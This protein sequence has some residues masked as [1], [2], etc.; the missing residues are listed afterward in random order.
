MFERLV[1][2][3][4][5]WSADRFL[6]T[7]GLAAVLGVGA[8]LR[9]RDLDLDWFIVDQA[10]DIRV[11]MGIVQGR[12]F[13][14]V[15]P[16]V[17]G[18]PAHTWGP[19]YFYLLAVPLAFSTSPLA[20]A[21]FL[22]LL[23]LAAVYLTY[24]FGARFFGRGVGLMSAALFATSPLAVMS[25]RG[26]WNLAPMPLFALAL[27]YCLFLVVI[28]RRSVMIV[29]TM[30]ILAGVVQLHFSGV[31]FLAVFVLALAV[32]RPSIRW[33]H[34]GLG[35]MGFVALLLPYLVTQAFDGWR[36]I[37]AMLTFSQGALGAA[38]PHDI[39]PS[40]RPAFFASADLTQWLGQTFGG[41][42]LGRI[43][44]LLQRTE[45]YLLLVGAGYL[46]ARALS[47]GTRRPSPSPADDSRLRGYGL[48]A[49]WIWAPVALL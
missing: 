39:W 9:L 33:G 27:L 42:R 32:Y 31:A 38:R 40:V 1:D 26:L 18:G 28:D 5:P 37:R 12:A 4:R 17:Q 23:N 22:S 7:L 46:I 2:R 25:G 15:G 21:T 14:L 36:D 24:H 19:L 35:T 41:S 43:G 10:R 44:W 8:Y 47:A 3:R 13:P 30:L 49:L 16:E 20:A 34:L 29:P 11:A 45:G 6:T 48:L